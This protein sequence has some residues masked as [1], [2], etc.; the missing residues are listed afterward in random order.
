VKTTKW[1]DHTY[2]NVWTLGV[3]SEPM[4]QG[5]E[6]DHYDR[7]HHDPFGTSLS[8]ASAE[9][10]CSSIRGTLKIAP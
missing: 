9:R 4:L 5:V 1:D 8:T 6:V 10:G 3:D 7:D 2:L